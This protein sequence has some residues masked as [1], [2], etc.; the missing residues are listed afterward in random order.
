MQDP[1]GNK[2]EGVDRAAY[3][4][5]VNEAAAIN[6]DLQRLYKKGNLGSSDALATAL[7]NVQ[8]D[9]TK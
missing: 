1:L 9:S 6:A 7:E 5:K 3:D 8:I 4:K 2:L